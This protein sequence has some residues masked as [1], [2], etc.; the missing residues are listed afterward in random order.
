[1]MQLAQL[2]NAQRVWSSRYSARTL[3][4]FAE[5]YRNSIHSAPIHAG[6][7]IQG[8]VVGCSQPR[9]STARFYIVDFGLKAEAPFT[10]KEIPGSSVVGHPVTMPLLA[11]EDDFNEPVMDYDRRSQ[12]RALSA[13]RK[14]MLL[15]AYSSSSPILHGRFANFKRSGAGVK[16]LG[17]DAFVPRHHVVALDRPI[18][19]TYAPFYVLNMVSEKRHNDNSFEVNA[20]LSSYGGF[21]F[22]MAN[23]VGRHS[24]WQESGGGTTKQ[25]QA[26]LRL[27]TRLLYQKNAAVRRIFPRNA[28]DSRHTRPHQNK[29]HRRQLPPVDDS[30]WLDD[31]SRGDWASSAFGKKPASSSNW[32][33]HRIS[34]QKR[35]PSNNADE[36]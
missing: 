31:L 12:L 15:T 4:T 28:R 21:L 27:L 32:Q 29:R 11:I 36:H 20:V 5:M 17:T 14:Q 25:R 13:E 34:M 8:H 30:A 23:L 19:G 3:A 1:M 7:V 33:K 2:R 6:D 16:V 24:A 10:S 35:S 18:L 9:S 26:Y 22:C